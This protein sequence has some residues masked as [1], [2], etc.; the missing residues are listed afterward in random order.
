MHILHKAI[1]QETLDAILPLLTPSEFKDGAVSA[2]Y[3]ARLVKNNLQIPGTSQIVPV[4]TQKLF[5]ALQQN[6][7]FQ[8]VVLPKVV[9]LHAFVAL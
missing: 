6:A 7:D 9:A 5:E 4:V 8:A 1:P 2:G 3:A